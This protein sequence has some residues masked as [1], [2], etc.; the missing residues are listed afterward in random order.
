[1]ERTFAE[2][3]KRAKSTERSAT[4][5]EPEKKPEE[6]KPPA[7]ETKPEEAEAK[8]EGEETK[9]Q[10][11]E[12]KPPG[13]ETKTAAPEKGKKVNPWK[14][15][16]QYKEKLAAAE[17]EVAQAKTGT[18]AEQEKTTYL[19]QIEDLQKRNTELEDHIRFV[20]YSRSK[21]FSEKYAEPYNQACARAA[22][23]VAEIPITD[24]STGQTRAATLD[25]VIGLVNMPLGQALQTAKEVFGDYAEYVMGHRK[26]IR[27]LWDKQVSALESEKKAGGERVKLQRE[28][29][30]RHIAETKE[31]VSKVWSEANESARKHEKY[32]RFFSPTESDKDFNERLE[33]GYA[34]VDKAFSEDP[35]NP[36]LPPK[37]RAEIVK[38]HAALRNRAAAFG[39]LTLTVERLESKLKAAEAELAKYKASIPSTGSPQAATSPQPT[40]NDPWSSV[41]SGLQRIAHS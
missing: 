21:D 8:P 39:P 12:T 23:E 29:I 32:G 1:M 28:Q 35:R 10:G 31:F 30:Q 41:R 25:D 33:K 40:A 2:L 37:E 6:T 7:D 38:R 5:A 19:K 27:A 24:P 3:R 16:D 17:K 15:V 4:T 22:S 9:P 11:D 13:E 18:M 20:D 26:E 34:L 14:L 36:K